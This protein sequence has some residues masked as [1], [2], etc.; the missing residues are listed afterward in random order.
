[1]IEKE[2]RILSPKEIVNYKKNLLID[3]DVILLVD[4]GCNDYVAFNLEQNK[5]KIFNI[6]DEI[7][8]CNVDINKY[9][10]ILKR[11]NL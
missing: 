1:M 8:F 2:E 6:V 7:F 3:I 11:S 10:E 4:I 5:F 9:I